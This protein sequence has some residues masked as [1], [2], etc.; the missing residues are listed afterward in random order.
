[1]NR[2]ICEK[3]P[4]NQYV[5]HL[6]FD[7]SSKLFDLNYTKK[8]DSTDYIKLILDFQPHNVSVCAK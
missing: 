2:K 4:L 8:K 3:F 7:H 6:I 1:M 5:N